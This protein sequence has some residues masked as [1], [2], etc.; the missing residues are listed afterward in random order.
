MKLLKV[1]GIEINE[2]ELEIEGEY[3]I[4]E[5]DG[6]ADGKEY[7]VVVKVDSEDNIIDVEVEEETD[8]EEDEDEEEDEAEDETEDDDS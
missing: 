3:K 2:V 6:T 1:K 4:Y 7:E 5:I 8:D